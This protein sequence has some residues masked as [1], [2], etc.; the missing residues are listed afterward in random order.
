MYHA[1]KEVIP[2]RQGINDRLNALIAEKLKQVKL[3]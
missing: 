3:I 2:R 1:V